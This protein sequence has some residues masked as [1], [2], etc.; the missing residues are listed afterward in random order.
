MNKMTKRFF[1]PLALAAGVSG[2]ALMGA[3]PAQAAVTPNW[4]SGSGYSCSNVGLVNAV[5]CIQA[6]PVVTVN[7]TN[8]PILSNNDISVLENNLN[9]TKVDV[10]DIDACV[11]NFYKSINVPITVQDILVKL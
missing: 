11:L 7:V 6:N 5:D 9:N 3:A 1:A 8:S 2:A 4:G 10:Q